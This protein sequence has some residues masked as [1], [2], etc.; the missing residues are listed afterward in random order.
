VSAVAVAAAAATVTSQAK[1]AVQQ[2]AAFKGSQ[3]AGNWQL[4]G[5]CHMFAVQ[6]LAVRLRAMHLRVMA[7]H[8]TS[9]AKHKIVSMSGMAVQ[10]HNW[11][12]AMH[13]LPQLVGD[14]SQ[15]LSCSLTPALFLCDGPAG[16]PARSSTHV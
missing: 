5:M 9:R 11:Q 2:A 1:P 12:C 4:A 15:Q 7:A 3:I 14:V 10:I 6:T 16:Q 13:A 8:C